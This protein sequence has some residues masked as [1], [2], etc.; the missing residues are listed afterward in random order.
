[1]MSRDDKSDMAAG[2]GAVEAQ[3]GGPPLRIMHVILSRGFAGSERAAA[4]ACM[5]LAKRHSVAVVVRSDHR[6]A[7]GASIRDELGSGVEVFEVPA[8]IGTR[9]RLESI[10]RAWA[11]DVV[12]THLR[13]GTRYI[14]R[15]GLARIGLPR[16][17]HVATPHLSINGRHYLWTDGLIC[18]S[19]WQVATVPPGY[20][21]RVFMVPNSLL[22]HRRLDAEQV[23]GLRATFGAAESDYVVGGVGRL[24]SRKGFDVLLEAFQRADL[25]CARLVIVGEGRER[26]S[27]QRMAGERVVFTGFRRDVKDLYQAFD[28]FVC[29]SSYEP[30]GR[31]IAEA[32][33]GGVPVVASDALG[34]RDLA[35]RYPIEIVPGGDVDRLASALRADRVRLPDPAAGEGSGHRDGRG[36]VSRITHGADG[37]SRDSAAPASACCGR[38]GGSASA[39]PVRTGLGAGRRRRTDAVP[40][41]RSRTREG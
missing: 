31:V 20:A 15:I 17:V 8:R 1:M 38:A 18:I 10:I 36:A 37:A 9:H 2:N 25:P 21:G 12:H 19:D 34:P 32:L 13:R 41:H 4:E 29:P 6:G 33:D 5:A 35:R 14:A 11:P 30:F 23:R 26:R 39:L 40:D 24:A 28:L 7:G 22:P 27:L 3:D 16:S